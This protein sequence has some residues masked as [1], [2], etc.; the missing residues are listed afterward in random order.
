M[1]TM[2]QNGLNGRDLRIKLFD[3]MK[4]K[5][6]V[7]N[8]KT[9]LRGRLINE[10]RG[11]VDNQIRFSSSTTQ[12]TLLIRALN[13]LI[14]DYFQGQR[15][16]YTTSVFIPEANINDYRT[17]SDE[18]ILRLL[19]ISTESSFYKKIKSNN[20]T[21]GHTS[22]LMTML[23]CI[24]SWLPGSSQNNSA[25]TSNDLWAGSVAGSTLD[26]KLN[27]LD[28]MYT[29]RRDDLTSMHNLSTE[30]KLLLFQK[31]IELR[32][33]ESLQQQMDQFRENEIKKIRDDERLK[34]QMELQTLRKELETLYKSKQDTLNEKEMR[35]GDRFKAELENERRELYAQRQTFLEELKTMKIRETENQRNLELRERSLTLETDRLKRLEDDIR[36]REVTLS[37]TEIHVDQQVQMKLNKLRFEI[38]QQFTERDKNFQLMEMRNQEEARRLSEERLLAEQAKTEVASLRKHY[39]EADSTIHRLQ[40]DIKVLQNENE[41]LREK[42]KQIVDYQAIR[43][44]NAVLKSQMN[45]ITSRSQRSHQH[46]HNSSSSSPREQSTNS[47]GIIRELKTV[48]DNQQVGQ[49]VVNDELIDL[50]TQIALLQSSNQP[51]PYFN[52]RFPSN[53]GGD[54]LS[55]VIKSTSDVQLNQSRYSTSSN[56]NQFIEDAKLRMLELD[57]EADRVEESYRDYQHRIMTK[58]PYTSNIQ[59]TEIDYSSVRRMPTVKLS[60]QT[61]GTT[62]NTIP[63]SSSLQDISSHTHK[64]NWNK[65]QPLI[66]L[67][68]SL[69][70]SK[71]RTNDRQKSFSQSNDHIFEHPEVIIK[72]T[73]LDDKIP[74]RLTTTTTRPF[75]TN[76]NGTGSAPNI[77]EHPDI[78]TPIVMENYQKSLFSS[79]VSSISSINKKLTRQQS[80]DAYTTRERTMSPVN[81][82][83]N[84]INLGSPV[85]SIDDIVERPEQEK[86]EDTSSSTPPLVSKG[87]TKI[88]REYDETS[89]T[90]DVDSPDKHS[91]NHNN[92]HHKPQS[93]E[94]DFW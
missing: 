77:L 42:T 25:Q 94:D 4:S 35:I 26:E 46:H 20:E 79:P 85:S 68:E 52:G 21:N 18:E 5:G 10:L 16:D 9:H 38:E 70:T 90:S 75:N 62:T 45:N 51:E 24:S 69:L 19:N 61:Q 31:N 22:L 53:H 48:L 84:Q 88:I 17:M 58:T 54:Y 93:E 27:N 78:K 39:S 44:E 11:G 43:E 40:S 67:N 64:F 14:I 63:A 71:N 49:K 81:Y 91:N 86:S 12:P 59:P 6:I 36:K 56:Y 83:T 72:P 66:N 47:Q 89:S 55:H 76:E 3:L 57:R 73:T 1:T 33:K 37:N 32:T 30:E 74:R 41:I 13:A 50:K 28:A 92:N 8:V 87:S 29:N 60:G 2:D 23:T 15:Y 7:D 34:C 82:N 80:A 65:D